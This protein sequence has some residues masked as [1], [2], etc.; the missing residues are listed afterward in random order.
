MLV[1]ASFA[2]IAR[3]FTR[4]SCKFIVHHTLCELSSV[5]RCVRK[6]TIESEAGLARTEVQTSKLDKRSPNLSSKIT[7][8]RQLKR[9]C[10]GNH[11]TAAVRAVVIVRVLS[12]HRLSHPALR[13]KTRCISYMC[14]E[15]NIYNNRV[16]RDKCHNNQSIY[17]IAEVLL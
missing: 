10:M 2:L 17:Y 3:G 9:N 5:F 11:N 14:Q 1:R 12:T 15:D 6:I 7:C 16:Y 4:G 8:L 13:N